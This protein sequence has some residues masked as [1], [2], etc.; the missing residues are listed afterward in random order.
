M[1]ETNQNT[2]AKVLEWTVNG[3]YAYW[4]RPLPERQVRHV[5]EEFLEGLVLS[6]GVDDDEGYF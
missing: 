4:D 3:A 6:D 1:A 2:G 5:S